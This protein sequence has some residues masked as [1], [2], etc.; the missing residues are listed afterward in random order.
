MTNNNTYKVGDKVWWFD[1]WDNMRWGTIYEIRTEKQGALSPVKMALIYENGR[2]GSNTGARLEECWPTREQCLV[3][4]KNKE[5]K[6][7]KECL[8]YIKTVEDL[9]RFMYNTDL[10][11]EFRDCVAAKA[12]T[13]KAKELLGID[14]E[15]N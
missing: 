9:V 12:V 2:K 14:L 1:S 3:A 7:Y 4:K 5:Q 10:T 11:S 13:E 15:E 8:D 6:H